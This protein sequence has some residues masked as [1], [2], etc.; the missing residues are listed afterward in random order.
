MHLWRADVPVSARA[1]ERHRA[2][3][4]ANI[5]T[6]SACAGPGADPGRG[7]IQSSICWQ[8]ITPHVFIPGVRRDKTPGFRLSH[9]VTAGLILVV[10]TQ[11]TQE[12]DRQL[13]G[14]IP[15]RDRLACRRKQLGF[16]EMDD[17]P[18]VPQLHHR[19]AL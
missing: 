7:D 11:A 8:K 10:K 6:I 15:Q 17:V 4:A 1:C 19:A 12:D 16:V 5:A 2:A 18:M 14:D 13:A 9:G 3:L